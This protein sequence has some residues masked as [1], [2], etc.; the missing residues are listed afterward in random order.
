MSS[1]KAVPNEVQARFPKSSRYELAWVVKHEMGPN[2]LWLTEFLCEKLVL[3]P[4]MRIL[5]LACGKALS[6]V[7]L[8]QNFDVQVWAADLWIP[9][10][11]NAARIQEAGLDQR[12]FPL[13]LNARELPFANEFF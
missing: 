6:S 4:G 12:V 2:P 13:K 3:K 1:P 10:S 11:D 7:F 9:A 5:D 8:A